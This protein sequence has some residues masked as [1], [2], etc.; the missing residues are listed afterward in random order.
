MKRP[1]HNEQSG[2]AIKD[3]WLSLTKGLYMHEH[4]GVS[5]YMQTRTRTHTQI[6]YTGKWKKVGRVATINGNPFLHLLIFC[7]LSL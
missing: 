4:T 6:T 7:R 3:Y 1:C 5:I 2:G